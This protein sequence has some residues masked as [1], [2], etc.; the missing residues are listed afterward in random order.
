M[1]ILSKILIILIIP[2]GF[3]FSACTDD[4]AELKTKIAELDKKIQKQEKDLREF[5][6]KFAPAK[7]FSA[8]IQRL[9]DQNDR[10]S[11]I[12]KTKV[13]PL[14][15]KLDEFRE[16]AQ[17]AQKERE[18]VKDRL[19]AIDAAITDLKKKLDLRNKDITTATRDSMA[20]KKQIEVMSKRVDELSR[21]LAEVRKELADNNSKLIAAVKKILPKVKDAAVAELKE[22]IQPLEQSLSTIKSGVEAEKKTLTAKAQGLPADASKEVQALMGRIKDLEDVVAAQK[23]ALLEI[24]TKLHELQRR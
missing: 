24:G 17:E 19:K 9:E 21:G 13:D 4:T 3:L 23:A 2:A 5:S 20:G 10:F 7:D 6:T 14:N 8:D 1:R 16:W 12:I 22:K 18:T 15:S 11:Q